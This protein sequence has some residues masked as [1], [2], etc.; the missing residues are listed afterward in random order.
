MATQDGSSTLKYDRWSIVLPALAALLGAIVG[1]AGSTAASYLTLQEN[2]VNEQRK[3]QADAYIKF[4]DNANKTNA[5]L[6]LYE[7]CEDKCESQAARLLKVEDTL[8]PALNRVFI[9]GSIDTYVTANTVITNLYDRRVA[10]Q[11]GNPDAELA[12]LFADLE[13]KYL[14]SICAEVNVVPQV[15][16]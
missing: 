16:D 4:L 5:Q 12:K 14:R 10:R 15:C 8:D 13:D 7:A 3:L 1:A 6:K 2:R 9:Y 11:R